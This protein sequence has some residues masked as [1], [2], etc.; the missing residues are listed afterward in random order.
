[1]HVTEIIIYYIK[2]YVLLYVFCSIS[3]IS[4]FFRFEP[5]YG[6]VP[7]TISI[8][9]EQVLPYINEQIGDAMSSLFDCNMLGVPSVTFQKFAQSDMLAK[10]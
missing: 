10:G 3:F 9:H 5:F 6:I 4:L 8:Q 1:M 7:R 2:L